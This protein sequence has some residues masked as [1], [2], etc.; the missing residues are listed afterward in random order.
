[1]Y[2]EIQKFYSLVIV[3]LFFT[4][5]DSL[6]NIEQKLPAKIKGKGM[7]VVQVKSAFISENDFGRT[8]FD[9]PMPIVF[10]LKENNVLIWRSFIGKKR[11][12]LNL[13][14]NKIIAYNP[15]SVYQ[16]SIAEEGIVSPERHYTATYEKGKWAFDNGR[17]YLGK[18]KSSWFELESYWV[19][20][21]PY[22]PNK[23]YKMKFKYD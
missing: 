19:P 14:K 5:C 1:M 9:N 13:K 6:K 2:S 8:M 11:G 4:S 3:I 21:M 16:F 20:S 23:M 22:S 18:N 7:H 10:L 15:E 17:I 12:H